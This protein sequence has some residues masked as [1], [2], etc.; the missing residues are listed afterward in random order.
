M[1]AEKINDRIKSMGSNKR[2]R[3]LRALLNATQEDLETVRAAFN[4]LVTKLNA[5]AG[6]A[7]TNYAPIGALN[8]QK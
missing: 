3:E 4:A 8:L 1:A 2:E 7:D 5:D 6:V